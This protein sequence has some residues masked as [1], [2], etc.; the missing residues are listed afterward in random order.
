MEEARR[1][2]WITVV[3]VVSVIGGIVLRFLPASPMWLD[4]AISASLA[5][6]A[7]RGWSHLAE[8][9]RHDGHP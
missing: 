1:N 6:E 9:L 4:E 5:R 3:V 7:D 2:R 8:A